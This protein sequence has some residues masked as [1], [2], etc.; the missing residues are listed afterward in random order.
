MILFW[1]W[2]GIYRTDHGTDED[3]DLR[4]FT[5]KKD[6]ANCIVKSEIPLQVARL[7][8]GT[9]RFYI[10]KRRYSQANESD[11][12]RR[13]RDWEEAEKEAWERSEEESRKLNESN[14]TQAQ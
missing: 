4:C 5:D 6:E 11:E 9:Y 10:G 8:D 14:H 13:R 1:A 2:D 3:S 12:P 7:R